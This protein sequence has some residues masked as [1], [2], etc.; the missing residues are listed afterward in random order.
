MEDVRA[1]LRRLS[2]QLTDANKQIAEL[3]NRVHEKPEPT[4]TTVPV[5]LSSSQLRLPVKFSIARPSARVGKLVAIVVAILLAFALME[6]FAVNYSNGV[7]SPSKNGSIANDATPL[8]GIEKAMFATLVKQMPRTAILSASQMCPLG[9]FLETELSALNGLPPSKWQRFP[10]PGARYNTTVP[11]PTSKNPAVGESSDSTDPP[12]PPSAAGLGKRPQGRHPAR[13][14]SGRR[15]VSPWNGG[16]RIPPNI[17]PRWGNAPIDGHPQSWADAHFRRADPNDDRDSVP[18]PTRRRQLSSIDTEEAASSATIPKVVLQ[19]FDHDY[20]PEGMAAA[21]Q[22]VRDANPEFEFITMT[23]EDAEA[24]ADAKF[25]PEDTAALKRFRIMENKVEFF[26]YL[27]L[28]HFGGIVM[29][30]GIMAAGNPTGDGVGGK[31][32]ELLSGER[33]VLTLEQREYIDPSRNLQ[34]IDPEAAQTAGQ[35][36]RMLRARRRRNDGSLLERVGGEPVEW[37]DGMM[38][39][40]LLLGCVKQHPFI[41]TVVEEIL[42]SVKMGSTMHRLAFDPMNRQRLGGNNNPAVSWRQSA[43]HVTGSGRLTLVFRKQ[44]FLG[45]GAHPLR[46]LVA[47]RSKQMPY[48]TELAD[49]WMQ[50]LTSRSVSKLY[51]T[52]GPLAGNT[53]LIP[54]FSKA[55]C[56]MG[57][58]SKSMTQP[59]L[60][61]RYPLY[62]REIQWYRHS[63]PPDTIDMTTAWE[64]LQTFTDRSC[65]WKAQWEERPAKAGSRIAFVDNAATKQRPFSTLLAL[66]RLFSGSESS[67]GAQLIP[68][69]I[70]QTNLRDVIPPSM[71]RALTS[72]LEKNPEYNYTFYSDRRARQFVAENFDSVTLAAFD[73]IIPGAFKADLFRLCWLHHYGG[74]YLDMDMEAGT[75]P[76]SSI[77][78]PTDRLVTAVDCSNGYIYNAF[79]AAVPQHPYI[80]EALRRAVDKITRRDLGEEALSITGPTLMQS[81]LRDMYDIQP[82]RPLFRA[83]ESLRLVYFDCNPCGGKVFES[84]NATVLASDGDVLRSPYFSYRNEMLR[85]IGQRY[86]YFTAYKERRVFRDRGSN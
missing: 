45:G 14:S 9:L 48:N 64:A 35:R 80:A 47:D 58:I 38:I 27:Y 74:V 23:W 82:A 3:R 10:L 34:H 37:E 78:R 29:N 57:A 2:T 41:A 43:E 17:P 59:I 71:R 25:S 32:S 68:R 44:E 73:D 66:K 18:P 60:W 50:F 69:T 75:A 49:Q 54:L 28:L 46:S 77:I 31:L 52:I 79:V 12:N 33:L 26:G 4:T 11:L 39:S 21:A 40:P 61:S 85:Y 24:F 36:G 55:N 56:L 16:N 83:N 8:A 51:T 62:G 65:G 1:E 15:P 67:S 81:I 84:N 42:A 63:V 70:M 30:P 7:F 13:Q 72:I 76:L 22:S 86:N 6:V 5:A 20:V 19:V 53:T